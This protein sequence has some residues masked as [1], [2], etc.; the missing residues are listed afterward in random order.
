MGGEKLL[1]VVEVGDNRCD[2]NHRQKSC[3]GERQENAIYHISSTDC[4]HG[5]TKGEET[6]KRE[7]RIP[8]YMNQPI[9]QSDL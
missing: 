4:K 8:K 5:G 9:L 7:K 2:N 3:A 1:D 6:K